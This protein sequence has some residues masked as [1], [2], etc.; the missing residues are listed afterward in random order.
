MEDEIR[1]ER[2][3]TNIYK[4]FSCHPPLSGQSQRYVAI[5][6]AVKI[7]ALTIERLAP[8]S[9]ERTIAID[10]LDEAVMWANAAIARNEQEPKEQ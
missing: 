1:S 8:D 3:I 10:K 9:R 7:A 6:D 4:R 2:I 5:R